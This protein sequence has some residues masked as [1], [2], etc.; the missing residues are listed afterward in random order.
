[1][2][3][4]PLLP[5]LL[6]AY[7]PLPS[8]RQDE[9]L[10]QAS[11]ISLAAEQT[12]LPDNSQPQSIYLVKTGL[13]RA[14]YTTDEGKEFSKEFYW[15]LDL[16]LHLRYQISGTPLPYSIQAC[17]SSVVY[18]LP[19]DLYQQLTCE[20]RPWQQ[21]HQQLLERHILF[22]ETKEELLL[23]NSTEQRVV[24]VYQLFPEFVQR[25]PAVML[26]TYIGITPESLSRIKKR[27][28][29]S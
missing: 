28:G 23:L 17:E 15:D 25:V 2:S 20:S 4:R 26:A 27:L 13:L 6:S 10:A 24:K 14:L 5:E 7:A 8:Y 9:F 11:K 19:L 18:A 29:L 21:Y 1:M 16:I 22:K 12:L 3:E